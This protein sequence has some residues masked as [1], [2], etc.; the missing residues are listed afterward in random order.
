METSLS[1]LLGG[2][3]APAEIT[4]DVSTVE[5]PAAVEPAPAPA[6]TAEEPTPRDEMGRFAKRIEAEAPEPSEPVQ[7]AEEAARMVPL[8]S[9]LEERRKRQA[10]EERYRSMAEMVRAQQAPEFTDEQVLSQPAET[11]RQNNA[12][13]S[14]E[15]QEQ[16]RNLKFELAE[17]LTRSLHADY[18]SVRDAFIAKVESKDPFAVAIAQQMVGQANPAKFVY[19]QARRMKQMEEVGDT[20][21]LRSRIEAEVRAKVMAEMRQTKPAVEVPA[22]LNS[23]PSAPAPSSPTDFEPTPLEN[24][25]KFHF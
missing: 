13:L 19:D 3:D 4:A 11:L 15:M 2:A 5:T 1:E 20:S 24:V 17:D 16:M 14:A 8:Q 12:R 9:M 22:S 10:A 6:T 7:T 18:D 25:A 21:A 23:I